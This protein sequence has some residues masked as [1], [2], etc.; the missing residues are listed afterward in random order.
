MIQ[1]KKSRRAV[2]R[3]KHGA[4]HG[5]DVGRVGGTRDALHCV[6]GQ[7][8]EFPRWWHILRHV[9]LAVPVRG[10]PSCA[11][12]FLR[13]NT[14]TDFIF[15]DVIRVV[16]EGSELDIEKAC[17]LLVVRIHQFSHAITHLFSSSFFKRAARVV[18]NVVR[19]LVEELFDPICDTRGVRH[20]RRGC[21]RLSTVLFK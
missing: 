3:G 15:N 1:G 19:L 8:S 5:R 16:H 18:G 9:C 17:H 6:F 11:S 10:L 4:E 21:I 2:G 7:L 12:S 13:T 20:G 14:S